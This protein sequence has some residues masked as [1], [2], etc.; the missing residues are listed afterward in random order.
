MTGKGR[1][2][3]RILVSLLVTAAGLGAAY[4]WGLPWIVRARVDREFRDAGF[5][6]ASFKVTRATLRQTWL[7]D[8]ALD[9][10]NKLSIRKVVICYNPLQ[11]I[12]GHVRSVTVSGASLTLNL[13]EHR[14]DWGPLAGLKLSPGKGFR[15]RRIR[16]TDSLLTIKPRVG[17][18]PVRFSGE[19][20]AAKEAYLLSAR[21]GLRDLDLNLK[22]RIDNATNEILSID[23]QASEPTGGSLAY[24]LGRLDIPAMVQVSGPISVQAHAQTNRGALSGSCAVIAKSV[25]GNIAEARLQVQAPQVKVTFNHAH[26]GQGMTGEA[27]FNL[28]TSSS[29][30]TSNQG[31]LAA[32]P[33][34]TMV[35]VKL[36]PDKSV[37]L[38][39]KSNRIS[40]AIKANSRQQAR[41]WNSATWHSTSKPH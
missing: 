27:V 28:N 12:D 35:I 41:C 7:E 6:T 40:M 15:F 29:T 39:A 16:I 30:I 11:S 24:L 25:H 23:A 14:L 19:I 20:I 3:R 38:Q 8:I 4:T 10:N 17:V 31:R 21:C 37:H 2:T 33:F 26:T 22:T 1:W 32:G 13:N 34:S 18:L 9:P 36:A 5:A